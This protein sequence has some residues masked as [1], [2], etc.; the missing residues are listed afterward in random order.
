MF[1]SKQ[2]YLGID[3]GGAS[4]KLV[5]LRSE[6]GRPRLVTY[7][8][9]DQSA[10]IVKSNL[11]A[12]QERVI[13]LIR[14]ILKEANVGSN[15]VVAALPSFSVFTSVI[16][17]PQM[18]E[19]ELASA[20]KWEAKKFVPMP[21]EEMVLDWKVIK[22][23]DKDE[24]E[25]K[26]KGSRILGEKKGKNLKILLT[27]APKNLV[28]RYI[29]IFNELKLELLTLETESLAL[30]RSLVDSETAPVM[31]IDIGAQATDISIVH[32][33]IPILSRSIDA[34]G[35]TITKAIVN[36]LNIDEERAEQFKRDFG[37]YSTAENRVPKTIEFVIGSIINEIKHCLNL[38]QGQSQAPIEKIILAGGSAYLPNLPQY[39]SSL[40]NIKVHIG[41]P[42]SR[43]S[44]PEELTPVLEEIGPR[45]SVAIGLALR[46]MVNS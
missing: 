37:M 25:E 32:D 6:A 40:L 8:Y 15:Q 10:D 23:V 22:K 7:G 24:K 33:N 26:E 18:S 27:A 13:F 11:K 16:T 20:V 3:I 29:F 9:L 38:Y 30:E 35:N 19:K 12:N 31:I 14:R 41:N 42:W 44:Y 45:F 4:I 36:S 28:Q 1:K 21:I 34:G 43:L 17:L 46:N 39:F 5:E 2:G